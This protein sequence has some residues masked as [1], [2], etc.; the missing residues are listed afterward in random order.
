MY[1]L[2]PWMLHRE[3]WVLPGGYCNLT[4]L[5]WVSPESEDDGLPNYV[6]VKFLILSA[7]D[8]HESCTAPHPTG[9]CS[10]LHS[11]LSSLIQAINLLL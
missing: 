7:L 11:L 5:E 6:S 9:F 3:M 1:M 2:I 4:L 8:T 10:H